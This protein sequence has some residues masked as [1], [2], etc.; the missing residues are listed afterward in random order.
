RRGRPGSIRARYPQREVRAMA[1]AESRRI[2]AIWETC[3]ASFGYDRFLFGE[4]SIA[5]AYFSPVV[6]RFRTYGVTLDASLQAYGDR[7]ARHPAVA[8]WVDEANAE[9]ERI[10]KYEVL[11]E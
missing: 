7:V 4:F 6:M 9:T 3:L 10:L 11:A 8:Q 5:D 2:A 1:Q